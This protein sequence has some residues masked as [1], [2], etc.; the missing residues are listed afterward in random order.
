M[1]RTL[2]DVRE[3]VRQYS[4]QLPSLPP[5]I[6]LAI[7]RLT[8]PSGPAC[9]HPPSILQGPRNP[10]LDSLKIKKAL[11]LV[12]KAWSSP[13]TELL[14]SDIVLR[15]MGQ[16][17]ALANTFRRDQNQNLANLVR[18]IRVD[19]C[20]VLTHCA[21]VVREDFEYILTQCTMLHSFVHIAHPQFGFQPPDFACVTLPTSPAAFNPTWILDLR[22]R[23]AGRILTQSLTTRLSTLHLDFTMYGGSFPPLAHLLS[24]APCLTYLELGAISPPLNDPPSDT[25]SLL[26]YLLFPALKT[27]CIYCDFI[28]FI[29]YVTTKWTMPHLTNLTCMAAPD[30]PTPLLS[31]HAKQLTYLHFMYTE[32]PHDLAANIMLLPHLHELCPRILHLVLLI[33]PAERT[34]LNIHSPT[35]RYLDICAPPSVEA[36]RAIAL[37][38]TAHAPQLKRVRMVLDMHPVIPRH[39]HPAHM[40]GSDRAIE[41]SDVSRIPGAEHSDE[42]AIWLTFLSEV[43]GGS[44]RT[45]RSGASG[46]TRGRSPSTARGSASPMVVFIL[47]TRTRTGR[48]RMASTCMSSSLRALWTRTRRRRAMKRR[49]AGKAGS[50]MNVTTSTVGWDGIR[51][52]AG[53]WLTM[54]RTRARTQTRI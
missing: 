12:C 26:P 33:V 42:R 11:V 35:L 3:Q 13:A 32:T 37:A 50:D 1:I 5:E 30:I 47:G 54:R 53:M 51:R 43:L 14:Y 48:T 15:R 45:S 28:P 9:Q 41:D 27:L 29:R 49:G 31:A 25:F 21:E 34:A 19:M 36:Y 16:I 7:F 10:W 17:S 22:Q 6:L 40:P 38:P 46:S 39:F 4:L 8:Q 23:R 52:R 2:A 20:V 24:S 44:R 18:A